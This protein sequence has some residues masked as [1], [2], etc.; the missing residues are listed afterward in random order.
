MPEPAGTAGVTAQPYVSTID[1]GD[2]FGYRD[3]HTLVPKRRSWAP[4]SPVT[5]VVEPRKQLQYRA[6]TPRV[7]S[8]RLPV[9]PLVTKSTEAAFE[10][11]Q[12]VN[13]AVFGMGVT[14]ATTSGR[15]RPH[16]PQRRRSS[17]AALTA[18]LVNLP[19]SRR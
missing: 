19:I 17:V 7:V 8:P 9:T 4:S 6:R 15:H 13:H 5:S 1:D 14:T 2:F 18:R 11:G 3:E 10:E 12:R 16:G